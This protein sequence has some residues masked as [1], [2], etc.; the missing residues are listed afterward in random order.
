MNGDAAGEKRY[1]NVLLLVF[2]S[3]PLRPPGMVLVSAWPARSAKSTSKPMNYSFVGNML[4]DSIG[5]ICPFGVILSE[6]S[7]HLKDGIIYRHNHMCGFARSPDVK[8]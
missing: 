3:W 1:R 4:S 7:H 6:S 5:R 2:T 8:C